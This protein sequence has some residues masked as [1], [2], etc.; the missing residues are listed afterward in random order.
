LAVLDAGKGRLHAIF[1]S[2][3]LLQASKNRVSSTS[4]VT[5]QLLSVVLWLLIN[6]RL[7]FMLGFE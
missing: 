6:Q 5:K 4:T 2:V 3:C 7:C 1:F